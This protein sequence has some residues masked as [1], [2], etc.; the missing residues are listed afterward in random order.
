MAQV[1]R[2]VIKHHH[3]QDR[4]SDGE[5]DQTAT[6]PQ[7]E[8]QTRKINFGDQSFVRDS[9]CLTQSVRVQTTAG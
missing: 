1:G 9:Y 5:I 2:C 8:L 7:W 4:E 3:Q 6:L